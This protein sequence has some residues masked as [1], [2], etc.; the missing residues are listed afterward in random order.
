V[1]LLTPHQEAASKLPKEQWRE[2]AA[3]IGAAER[4]M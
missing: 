1:V 3:A 2:L 4:M